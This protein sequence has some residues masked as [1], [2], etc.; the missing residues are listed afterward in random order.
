MAAWLPDLLGG[1]AQSSPQA[2]SW[3]AKG[4]GQ[5]RGPS[6]RQVKTGM[7]DGPMIQIID[8]AKPGEQIV[9]KGSLFIDRVATGS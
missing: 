4:A 7:T 1:A 3:R 2:A 6:Y 8:G 5:R 9:V